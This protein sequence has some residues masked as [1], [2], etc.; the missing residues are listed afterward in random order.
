[1]NSESGIIT[2]RALELFLAETLGV[3]GYA[4]YGPNGLQVEGKDTIRRVGFAV[5]A[6]F[7]SIH[8]A[9]ESKADALIVHHGLLWHFSGPK[10]LVG[11][12]ARRIFPLVQNEISLFAYH[13]PLDAHPLVGNAAG[14]ARAL[15]LTQLSP[16]GDYK[17]KPTGVHGIFE[18][19]PLAS[20]LRV[21]IAQTLNHAVLFASP[22]ETA[23]VRTL[24]I[25][26]GGANRDWALAHLA[27][28]DAYLTGEMSEHDWHESKEAGIHMYAGGHHATEVFGVQSLM[29]LLKERFDL[30]CFYIDSEN[31]A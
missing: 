29:A 16:F 28:L 21:K 17:G 4:D 19:E 7:D 10:P 24:G 3:S 31:P 25:I 26:T 30:D 23:K 15:G 22:D 20:A 9:V 1:M 5:S 14:L 2:R 27:G 18:E 13:L 6:T 11:A 8:R 12:Y